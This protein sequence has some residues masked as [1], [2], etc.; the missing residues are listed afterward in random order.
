ME[1]KDGHFA[2]LEEMYA[3]NYKLV[4]FLLRIRVWTEKTSKML[5]LRYGLKSWNILQSV[6]KWTY[7]GCTIICGN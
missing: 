3:A 4:V 6:L 5:F 1:S 7:T 2:D